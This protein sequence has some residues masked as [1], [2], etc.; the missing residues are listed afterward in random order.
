MCLINMLVRFASTF[1]LYRVREQRRSLGYGMGATASAPSF[2]HDASVPVSRSGG[3]EDLP[4]S[5][6]SAMAN[7]PRASG[8]GGQYDSRPLQP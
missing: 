2:G 4:S 1:M 8:G 5:Y 3:Y 6:P 7:G